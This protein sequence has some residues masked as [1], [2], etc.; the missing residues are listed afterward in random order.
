MV[1]EDSSLSES[2]VVLDP[3][4][5]ELGRRSRCRNQNL[6][7]LKSLF[8]GGD[9]ATNSDDSIDQS[10]S[11]APK[12]SEKLSKYKRSKVKAVH[13][14][15]KA[16]STLQQ[17]VMV[18]EHDL[19]EEKTQRSQAV[20]ALEFSPDGKHMATAGQDGKIRIW[21][22]LDAT[23][24]ATSLTPSENPL[25]AKEPIKIFSD[26]TDEITDLKW[27][28]NNF[29]ITASLDRTVRLWHV[30]RNKCLAVF[31][32]PDIVSSVAFHPTDDR[33]F[34]TG[35]LDKQ[36]SLWSIPDR[37]VVYT[38]QMP[39]MVTAVSFS[40]EGTS[41]L[42]GCYN[43]KLVLCRTD[44]LK[45]L[46]TAQVGSARK[47]KG[48]LKITGTTVVKRKDHPQP[49]VLVTSNSSRVRLYN[50]NDL[51]LERR[52]RGPRNDYSQTAA[53]MS[54]D[55]DMIICGSEDH[56][57]YFWHM[58]TQPEGLHRQVTQNEWV[59]SHHA[60][61]SVAQFI[62]QSALTL[63]GV[64]GRGFVAADSHGIVR[65]FLQWPERQIAA[66]V[67]GHL[68]AAPIFVISYGR[69]MGRAAAHALVL[70][71]L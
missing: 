55:G 43:G 28:K 57:T 16:S 29:I 34:L 42:A 11:I 2:S 68:L 62:P 53:A 69:L 67:K 45:I 39:D 10:N 56:R 40:P 32:P 36:I 20:W 18:E 19:R 12:V 30:E 54:D 50:L 66:Q 31:H 17:V 49:L 51:S 4:R 8:R 64:Q 33:F 23:E 7:N 71:L 60:A 35:S 22:T 6:P 15:N 25:F 24:R 27:S 9:P 37:E 47:P 61:V 44:R 21:R 59:H 41:C 70:G 5:V 3:L 48:T 26:H 13:T 1:L 58:N 52:L 14:S 63:A 46:K 65:V 38:R